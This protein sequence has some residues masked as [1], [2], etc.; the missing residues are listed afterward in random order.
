MRGSL[1]LAPQLLIL[2][3]TFTKGTVDT[4]VFVLSFFLQLIELVAVAASIFQA[5]ALFK[6]NRRRAA[7]INIFNALLCILALPSSIALY[8]VGITA[9]TTLI[10]IIVLL[11][12]AT[13]LDKTVIDE[14]VQDYQNRR[15]NF[16]RRH[17]EQTRLL[18]EAGHE[19]RFCNL[20]IFYIFWTFIFC[21]ILGLIFETI[22]H[23]ALFGEYQDRAGLLF[24]PFSPIYG[25]GGVIMTVALNRFKN[26]RLI[27]IFLIS[28]VIGGA[29][30]FL[31]SLF[32]ETAFGVVAWDYTGSFLSID[33]RTNGWFMTMWGI[34]GVV[35]VKTFFPLLLKLL[36]LIPASWR[37]GITTVCMI[38]MFVDGIMTFQ[39]I[40]CW[41]K[42]E[43]GLEPITGLEIFYANNFDNDFMETRFAS[44]TMNPEDS[45]R[46]KAFESQ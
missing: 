44:M 42:R 19:D 41:Y 29:F 11:V 46:Y 21:S 32:L 10:S 34:L 2:I 35:W 3:D 8:G 45:V 43:S 20:N 5:V 7:H 25:F 37:T 24:G 6:N 12:I 27:W 18:E 36:N 4:T 28:A 15:L 38:L 9:L 31:T 23:Y 30:E 39:A 16:K 17:Q 26:S 1:E 22:Y 40:D 13:L 33:G 14:L